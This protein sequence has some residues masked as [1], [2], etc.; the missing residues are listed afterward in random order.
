MK[1]QN[2]FKVSFDVVDNKDTFKIR[3]QERKKKK[4]VII[5]NNNSGIIF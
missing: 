4:Q 5:L 2:P 1:Y 3:E